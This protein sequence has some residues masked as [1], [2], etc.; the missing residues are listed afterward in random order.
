[1]FPEI[2]TR[3]TGPIYAGYNTTKLQS[4]EWWDKDLSI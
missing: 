3:V 2:T 4:S 1:M